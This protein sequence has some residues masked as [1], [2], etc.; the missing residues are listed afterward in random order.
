MIDIKNKI[1]YTCG[2]AF[3]PGLTQVALILK[4]KPEW[5]AGCLNGIGGKIDHKIDKDIYQAMSREFEEETGVIIPGNEWLLFCTYDGGTYI[6]FF[7]TTI[8][9]KIYDVKTMEEEQVALYNTDPLPDNILH[10]LNWLIPMAYDGDVRLAEVY[11]KT[12][13]P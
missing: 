13:K 3:N 8:T 5:Q 2:F 11:H 1:L 12:D 6:V 9:P 10:N 7:F 4:N